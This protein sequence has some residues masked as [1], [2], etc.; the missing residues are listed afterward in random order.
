MSVP[1]IM[2]RILE[3]D[4]RLRS[5]IHTPN[6]SQELK[7]ISSLPKFPESA[8]DLNNIDNNKKLIYEWKSLANKIKA[9]DFSFLGVNWP[10]T[11]KENIWHFDPI[12]Q[13]QWPSNSYCFQINYRNTEDYG[14]IKYVWELN[15]LQY[16]QPLAALAA[17]ENDKDLSIYCLNHIENWIDSNPP[18][19][20]VNWSS[21]IELA[22]RIISIL[23][24][25]SLLDES[26]ISEQQKNKFINTLAHHG[27]WLMRFPSCF[28]SANNHLIA[29]ASALYLLGKVA[30]SLPNAKSWKNYG[31]KILIDEAIK[32]IHD[33]GVGVEQSPTY[34]AF[35]IEWLLLCGVIGKVTGEDFPEKYWARIEKAGEFLHWITDKSGNQP[36]IGDNDEGQVFFFQF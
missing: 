12:S 6:F 25:I 5:R 29:E 31:K 20:G 17:I 3:L 24:V 1:E 26:L 16:L 27:Y 33:D 4:K 13:K 18:Y 30:P 9:N 7:N 35:T 10:N 19:K 36:L 22:C 34:T 32:Q 11:I 8:F 28:S 21:G 14:D 2:H 23:V 15:R